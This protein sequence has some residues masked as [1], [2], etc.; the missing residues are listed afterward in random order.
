MLTDNTELFN[1]IWSPGSRGFLVGVNYTIK[2]SPFGYE[3]VTTMIEVPLSDFANCRDAMVLQK[4]QRFE[5]L[6]IEKI[7]PELWF[8][9]ILREEIVIHARAGVPWLLD[10]LALM[11][12]VQSEMKKDDFQKLLA[13]TTNS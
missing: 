7:R 8:L 4:Y 13:A 6:N 1:M 11:S 12:K 3:G 5:K 2:E 9:R 10:T